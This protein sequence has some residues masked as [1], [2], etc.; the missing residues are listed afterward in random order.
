MTLTPAYGRD[1]KSKKSVLAD[2]HADKDFILHTVPSDPFGQWDGKPAN[3]SDL[4][5]SGFNQVG[6]RYKRLT[7]ILFVEL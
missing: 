7:K 5:A 2:F 3:R 1:Y 6:I 4:K